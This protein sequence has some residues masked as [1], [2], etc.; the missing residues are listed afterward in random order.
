MNQFFL[1]LK[2]IVANWKKTKGQL[3]FTIL[4]I[5]IASTLWSSVDIVNNQT[6]KAQKRAID[7]LQTAFKP[8]IIDRELSYVSQNDY[9]QLRQDGWLVNPVIR[10]PLENSSIIIVGIDLLADG[11]KILSSEKNIA[12]ENFF[13]MQAN[14]KALLFGSDKTFENSCFR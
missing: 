8:I 3:I 4:G 5:A 7:L 1:I 6:I 12:T 14:G 11:K 13:E 2:V 10:A 9:I